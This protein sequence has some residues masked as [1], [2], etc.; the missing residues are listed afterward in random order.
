MSE[1]VEG[2]GPARLPATGP[3]AVPGLLAA[4]AGVL[5]VVGAVIAWA[6]V[7]VGAP[8]GAA[9][10]TAAGT[11]FTEGKIVLAVGIVVAAAGVAVAF[12]PRREVLV[13]TAVVA[14]LGGL[15][16]TGTAIY[17]LSRKSDL[18]RTFVR[19]FRQGFERSTGRRLTDAEIR[20]LMARF[21]ISISLGPGPYVALAAGLIGGAGGGAGLLVA[22]R[23]PRGSARTGTTSPVP[24][25]DPAWPTAP[26]PPAVAPP[27]GPAEPPPDAP[28]G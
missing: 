27:P 18:D 23:S 16:V 13:A 28:P 8:L 10:R 17:Y 1:V 22:Q 14:A 2:A 11:T 20:V 3:T 6:K 25:P 5:A 26:A 15:A 12:A 9:S 21:G 7:S 24:S 19:G 4:A